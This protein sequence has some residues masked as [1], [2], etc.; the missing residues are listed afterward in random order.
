MRVGK[1]F[2]FFQRVAY[3]VYRLRRDYDV[4]FRYS[5]EQ[6]AVIRLNNCV[7][8]DSKDLEDIEELLG[9][10]GI[11]LHFWAVHDSEDKL[12]VSLHVEEGGGVNG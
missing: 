11:R 8:F 9:S 6:R 12:C 4:S 3:A 2:D 7:Y 5:D 1:D 10:L